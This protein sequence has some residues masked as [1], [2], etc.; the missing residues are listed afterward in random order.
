MA[1]ERGSN[2]QFQQ[3]ADLLVGRGPL[4]GVFLLAAESG[5]RIDDGE[6]RER[7]L[8][9]GDLQ[10]LLRPDSLYTACIVI[11]PD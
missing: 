7:A 8:L 11:C 4:S 10:R 9:L 5:E 3:A 2:G 6:H 1:V